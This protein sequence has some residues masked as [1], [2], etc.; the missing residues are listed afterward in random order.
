MKKKE[1]KDGMKGCAMKGE[2]MP[3]KKEMKKEMKKKK[4]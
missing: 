3:M 4:K 1:M 2:S